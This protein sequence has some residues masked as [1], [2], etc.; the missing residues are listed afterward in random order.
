GIAAVG[1]RLLGPWPAIAAVA[2]LATTDTFFRYGGAVRLDP[3]LVLL[4]NAAAVP[5]LLGWRSRR[6]W[7]LACSFAALAMLVKPPFG[8]V[9]FLAASGARAMRDRSWTPLILGALGVLLACMPL[10]AFLA[11]DRTILH[12]GWWDGFL[13]DQ[14]LGSAMGTRTDGSPEWWFPL[15]TLA[16]RFW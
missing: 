13:R 14:V 12:A 15:A 2:V 6:S 8:L 7:L 16:G 3:P 11:A 4:A 1:R 5:A 10:L 9:P